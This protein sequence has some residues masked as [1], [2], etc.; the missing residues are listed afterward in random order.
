MGGLSGALIG[1]FYAILNSVF[2]VIFSPEA[3]RL[4]FS[5]FLSQAAP[6]ALWKMFIFTLLAVIAVLIFE[7]RPLRKTD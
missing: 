1:L 6:S 3:E 5:Q 7:A 4:A 2:I